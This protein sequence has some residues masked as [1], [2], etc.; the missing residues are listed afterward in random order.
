[1][2]KISY[3]VLP[4]V[5]FLSNHTPSSFFVQVKHFYVDCFICCN[6]IT[7]NKHLYQQYESHKIQVAA[8]V[9][10]SNVSAPQTHTGL[11][12]RSALRPEHV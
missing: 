12:L 3:I 11:L 6:I 8:V 2:C 10:T 1:M 9:L 7:L 4:F 5:I